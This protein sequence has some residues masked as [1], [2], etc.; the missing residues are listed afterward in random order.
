MF[1]PSID[2]SGN[3]GPDPGWPIGTPFA[4]WLAYTWRAD[5]A[6]GRL[7]IRC[8]EG[9]V[10]SSGRRVS[11][12]PLRI[13]LVSRRSWRG[14]R[15]IAPTPI[16][17]EPLPPV[18]LRMLHPPTA[19][20]PLPPPRSWART[21]EAQATK[22]ATT[23]LDDAIFSLHCPRTISVA[24]NSVLTAP[25]R[26]QR[27]QE[28]QPVR[29]LVSRQARMVAPRWLARAA[30][31]VTHLQCARR[32]RRISRALNASHNEEPSRRPHRWRRRLFRRA[33]YLA[34]ASDI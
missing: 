11:S 18:R 28:R 30:S 16:A 34:N 6:R 17:P 27:S 3:P 7:R 9:A 10:S 4:A 24:V 21:G 14:R 8:G 22:A 23:N 5:R 1:L 25:I 12:R 32:R 2:C 33:L 29:S 31:S 20:P 19:P 15:T 13:V 26:E